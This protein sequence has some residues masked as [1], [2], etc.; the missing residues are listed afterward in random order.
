MFSNRDLFKNCLWTA[1]AFKELPIDL[2]LSWKTME[3]GDS[4][5][6]LPT[7]DEVLTELH[8]TELTM[9]LIHLSRP[10]YVE[11]IVVV[12]NVRRIPLKVTETDDPIEQAHLASSYDG[13]KHFVPVDIYSD[14]ITAVEGLIKIFSLLQTME[15][16]G[17]REHRR[18]GQYSLLH[19]DM[20]IFWQLLRAL[21]C[22]PAFARIRHDLFLIFGF[23]HAYHYAYVALWDEFRVT[24]LAKA[25]WL[26]YPSNTLMRRPK[27]T[28]SSTFFTWLRLAYPSFREK[29]VASIATLKSAVSEWQLAFLRARREGKKIE[30]KNQHLPSY[31]HLL[32]LYHLLEFCIPCIQDYGSALKSNNWVSFYTC[33]KRMLLFYISCSSKGAADYA[34]SMFMFDHLLRYWIRLGLPIVELFKWNHTIFSEESGEIALSVLSHSQPPTKRS[35]LKNAQ[36]YWILTRQRYLS[37]RQ[38]QDLP[39][40]KKHRVAGTPSSSYYSPIMTHL[41]FTLYSLLFTHDSKMQFSRL[42]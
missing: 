23:W 33:F 18:W 3:D 37:V 29:L 28:Q 4:V 9:D 17:T 39:R 11:S 20:K 21:Y 15:G 25:F 5:A 30:N 2:D 7:I 27:N 14:N 31:V 10:F 24:F 32:N 22:Y 13:L 8:L 35:E 16:F 6:A 12:R 41:L 34:R 42:F 19:V 36:D 26:L 1:H 38:G 40:H